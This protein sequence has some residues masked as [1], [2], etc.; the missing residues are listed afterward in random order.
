MWE[1]TGQ[2]Q[3]NRIIVSNKVYTSHRLWNVRCR[4]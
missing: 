4:L 3:A 2:R 1:T